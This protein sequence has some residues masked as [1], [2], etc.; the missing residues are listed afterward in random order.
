MSIRLAHI[1]SLP[2]PTKISFPFHTDRL[3]GTL[4]EKMH[5]WMQT[6]AMITGCCGLSKDNAAQKQLFRERMLVA[7]DLTVALGYMHSLKLVYRDVRW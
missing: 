1:L 3:Y 4:D 6:Q 2:N 5:L 7:Y